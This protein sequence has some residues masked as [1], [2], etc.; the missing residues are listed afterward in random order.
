MAETYRVELQKL[1]GSLPQNRERTITTHEGGQFVRRTF[2][3]LA[4]D[5]A[6]AIEALRA[7]G[8]R[9]GMRVGII[10]ENSYRW[11]VC[12]LALIELRCISVPMPET[13]VSAAD[14]S[15]FEK[16]EL[17]L[18][19]VS[20]RYAPP[21]LV[22][23]PR[24][25]CMDGDNPPGRNADP[26][27]PERFAMRDGDHSYVVGSGTSGNRKGMI[28]WRRGAE[29]I[30][31]EFGAAFGTQAGDSI[32]I[33][34]PLWAWQ[35]RLF[36]YG[37]LAFGMDLYV[38]DSPMVFHAV[39]DLQPTIIIGPP[40]F[41]ETIQRQNL[42]RLFGPRTRVLITGMAK[43]RRDTLEYFREAGLPLFEVYALTETGLVSA[44]V[45]AANR[46][47]SAGSPVP[48]S[49]V[50]IADDGE[51]LV[52]KPHFQTR[53][54]FREVPRG[55]MGWASGDWFPTGDVGHFDADGFLYVDGRKDDT[56]TN[57]SGQKIQPA[58][59][60]SELENSPL[61]R[62][63]VVFQ[64]SDHPYLIAVIDSDKRGEPDLA[65]G[66]QALIDA[67][68][69]KLPAWF[70][71]ERFIVAPEPFTPQNG[72]LTPNFK[73]SRARVAQAFSGAGAKPES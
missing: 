9:S 38:V 1:L 63:A 47:G 54:Y 51:I 58:V 30:I 40:V 13:D 64:D 3:T 59:I 33:F 56:I 21:D 50:R 41:Y 55:P 46:L 53:G 20:S 68:N 16:N 11:L 62:K 42:C 19:L 5:T 23:L 15:L 49:E 45:P 18:L 71:I 10:S 43:A 48:G 4:Q 31:E 25:M 7:C 67:V 22:G 60:E 6:A 65:G 14:E 44:N 2:E 39:R 72:F 28:V 32:L 57:A 73:V 35:Q 29:A 70:Q 26:A 36:Y 52:K 37:A 17:N 12:D 61:V 27:M 8:I 66:L 69:G 34:M 24:I